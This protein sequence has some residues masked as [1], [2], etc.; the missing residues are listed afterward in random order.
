MRIMIYSVQR[1]QPNKNLARM[2]RDSLCTLIASQT[3]GL[4][5]LFSCS[6]I[7]VKLHQDVAVFDHLRPCL[8]QRYEA[9]VTRFEPEQLILIDSITLQSL[10]L[11][12]AFENRAFLSI[13]SGRLES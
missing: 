6:C 2:I 8:K 4:T 13:R 10:F 7:L 9:E 1:N 11:V 5:K 3:A 12:L